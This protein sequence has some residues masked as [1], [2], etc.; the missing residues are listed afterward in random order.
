M[1]SLLIVG[2]G[3]YGQLIKEIAILNNFQKID[4]LDDSGKEA[5]GKIEDLE[6]LQ[7]RYTNTICSIGNCKLRKEIS[8]RIINNINIIHPSAIVSTSAKLGCGCVVEAGSII[9]ANTIIE[10]G[11][12]ICAGAVINHNSIIRKYSQ[13]DCNA[14]IKGEVLEQ[15]KV[16]PCTFW[17]G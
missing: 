9:S 16:E 14:V 10:D 17:K 8:S 6:K 15:T 7:G 2:S 1:K 3:Q 11:C 4:F 13:I 5:I 12:F